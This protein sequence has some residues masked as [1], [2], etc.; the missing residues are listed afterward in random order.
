MIV[1]V[2]KITRDIRGIG[3]NQDSVHTSQRT[4]RAYYKDQSV[5]VLRV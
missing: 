2:E 4:R 5:K 3:L 1:A